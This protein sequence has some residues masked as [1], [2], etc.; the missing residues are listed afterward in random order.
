MTRYRGTAISNRTAEETFDYL[1]QFSNAAEWDP[2]VGSAERLD[3]GPVGLG[4][5]FRLQVKV[6][7]RAI[8]LDYRIVAYE[9]P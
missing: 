3:T 7:S 6:G 1:A 9:R 2:G 8:P 5:V 4:S